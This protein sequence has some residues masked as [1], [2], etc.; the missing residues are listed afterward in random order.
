MRV[1]KERKREREG[2]QR[3]RREEERERDRERERE[4]QTDRQT[5]RQTE[6]GGGEELGEKIDRARQSDRKIEWG[7][8]R[9]GGEGTSKRGNRGEVVQTIFS[10][11]FFFQLRYKNFLVHYSVCL[12]PRLMILEVISYLPARLSCLQLLVDFFCLPLRCHI[13]N[14]GCLFPARRVAGHCY[15]RIKSSAAP[16]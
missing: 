6:R 14:P 9:L 16:S 11:L 4:R 1:E 12:L 3:E 7:E 15:P 8:R 5:D 13:G 10:G 2:R